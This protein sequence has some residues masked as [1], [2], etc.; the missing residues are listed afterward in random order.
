M[1]DLKRPKVRTLAA[2]GL[3]VSLL[4]ALLLFVGLGGLLSGAGASVRATQR[5]AI[6][7]LPPDASTSG[8]A[9]IHSIAC[10]SSDSCAVAGDYSTSGGPGGLLP[11][12]SQAGWSTNSVSP[13]AAGSPP[14][15][16]FDSVA[17]PSAGNC[18][19]VG[20]YVTSQGAR[21]GVFVTQ[22]G[23]LWG[24]GT[25][26][27]PPADAKQIGS[28][29]SVACPGAGEC[30]AVGDYENSSGDNQALIATS[31][32]GGPVTGLEAPLPQDAAAATSNAGFAGSQLNAVSCPS[33]STC[34]AVGTYYDNHGVLQGLL[35]RESGSGW[36]ATR[37]PLPAG[38]EN[39]ADPNYFDLTAV[40]C[41]AADNC[42]AVGYYPGASSSQQGV[43]LTLA[44]GTWS[45]QQL[46]L[47][48]D[49]A[50]NP[51][52]QLASVACV[53]SGN[54]T[55]AGSYTDSS[56]VGHALIVTEKDGAWSRG[57]A[58]ALPADAAPNQSSAIAAVACV[59]SSGDCTAV[60][61]YANS[62]GGQGL[63]FAETGGVWGGGVTAS[64][65]SSAGVT[66]AA[67]L[68]AVACPMSGDCTTIGSYENSAG[69]ARPFAVTVTIS[70]G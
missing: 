49:A 41:P 42:S 51:G 13:P 20:S 67:S 56:G 31:S 25:E 50:Q 45:N 28:F 32:A 61:S 34:V 6:I 65:P 5:A 62:S 57:T 8:V 16:L 26:V 14:R 58:P 23:G 53:S 29:N 38:A 54:C 27:S 17:C 52:V 11:L 2:G 68:D 24:Q 39:P 36:T 18:T 59:S 21:Q 12:K 48:S 47:P 7:P 15:S 69:R 19:A 66:G 37:A 33:A 3:A 10:S 1:R 30:V 40:A 70:S 35:L 64:L 43:L 46:S 44:N 22:S 9:Y 63:I 4:V 55:A 60:G